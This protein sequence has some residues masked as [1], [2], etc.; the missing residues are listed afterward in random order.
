VRRGLLGLGHV[1]HLRSWRCTMY[2]AFYGFREKPFNLTPDPDFLYLGP[3][4]RKV[5]SYLT[6]GLESGEGFIQ[7]AGEI[8]SGKTTLVRNLMRNLHPGLKLAYVLNPRGT[9]RQLLR[10][11]L[12][13]LGVV[14]LDDDQPREKLLAAFEAFVKEQAAKSLPVVIIFDEAQN[15]DPAALEEIRMLSNIEA[16][17]KKLVQI[18]FVG[19]PELVDLMNS[20]ELEQLNQRIA[21]RCR[22]KPLSPE[23]TGRYVR[24]RLAAAGCPDGL[25]KFSN[26]A[27]EVIHAYSHGIPRKINIACNAVLLAGFIDEKK[28]FNGQYARDAIID[29]DDSAGFV[30][31]APE[32]DKTAEVLQR[33]EPAGWSVGKLRRSALIAALVIGAGL[34]SW[35]VF[36][37]GINI[38]TS[39]LEALF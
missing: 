31:P 18:I 3:G 16:D 39:A 27:Y 30:S 24:H 17:K 12:D 20:P 34:G 25:V 29:M 28:S 9:F 14:S 6:Y 21:V 23:E 36:G 33:A 5:M 22:L 7:V 26:D 15:L 1:S 19:Q 10:I 38:V 37:G 32:Q 35:L 11:I 2:E 8:G 4:H 13:D